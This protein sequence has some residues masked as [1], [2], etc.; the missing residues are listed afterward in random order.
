LL[1][2]LGPAMAVTD[3]QKCEAAVEVASGKYCAVAITVR[4]SSALARATFI[5]RRSSRCHAFSSPY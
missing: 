4:R 1:V 2:A 5:T 3:T